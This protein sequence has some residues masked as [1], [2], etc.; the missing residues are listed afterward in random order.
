MNYVFLVCVLLAYAGLNFDKILVE[1]K[2]L[3]K[4]WDVTN[5]NIK[6]RF[7]LLDDIIKLFNNINASDTL[8]KKIN[9][10]YVIRAKNNYSWARTP[11]E[12]MRA[13]KE[14]T[15]ALKNL[16]DFINN[17][18]DPDI[19]NIKVNNIFI[20]FK[21]KLFRIEKIVLNHAQTYNA[22][23]KKYNYYVS[24]IPNKYYSKLFGYRKTRFFKTDETEHSLKLD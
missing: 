11:E 22:S 4:L 9:I 16:F 18:S 24:M 19:D 6:R 14:L 7:D 17:S 21:Q 10:D 15:S 23:V 3:N 1:K 2:N 20:D 5:I 8:N 12:I 13:N